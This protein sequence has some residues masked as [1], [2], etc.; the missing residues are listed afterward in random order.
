MVKV[1]RTLYWVARRLS[2]A[3][4]GVSKRLD[5]VSYKLYPKAEFKG[6]VGRRQKG[7]IFD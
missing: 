5:W 3:L 6:S 1:Y 4:Y 2:H 7:K